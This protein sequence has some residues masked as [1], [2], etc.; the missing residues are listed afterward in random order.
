MK[1]VTL[2]LYLSPAGAARAERRLA[3]WTA[4]SERLGLDTPP[5]AHVR[6]NAQQARTGATTTIRVVE[7]NDRRQAELTPAA[8]AKRDRRAAR[9]ASGMVRS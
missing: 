2:P 8:V 1:T 3:R 5:P 9:Y 6:R 7:D 4:R